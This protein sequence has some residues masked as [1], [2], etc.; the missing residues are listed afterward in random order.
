MQSIVCDVVYKNQNFLWNAIKSFKANPWR[1]RHAFVE[2]WIFITW[3][4]RTYIRVFSTLYNEYI[5]CMLSKCFN[6][7]YLITAY[8]EIRFGRNTFHLS[9]F[10]FFSQNHLFSFVYENVSIIS[11]HRIWN[12]SKCNITLKTDRKKKKDEKKGKNYDS[13]RIIKWSLVTIRSTR[14]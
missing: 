4:R 13:K 3:T 5:V 12:W 14:K 11:K 1:C 6:S 2:N 9:C 10:F 7:K 8:T